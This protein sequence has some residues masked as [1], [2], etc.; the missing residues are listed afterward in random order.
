MHKQPLKHATW[1]SGA[2]TIVFA[3]GMTACQAVAAADSPYVLVTTESQRV[4]AALEFEIDAPNLKASEWILFVAKPPSL[5][6]QSIRSAKLDPS[7]QPYREIS[8]L[9]RR[10]LRA[11]IPVSNA[12]QEKRIAATSQV[13]ATLYARHLTPRRDGTA[14]SVV[15]PLSDAER[16]AAL[17]KSSMF[18]FAEEPFTDW[19]DEHRLHRRKRENDVDFGRRVFLAIVESYEYEYAAKMT[20]NAAHVCTVDKADCGGMA[21]LFTAAM[22]ANDIPSRV[23]SGCWAKSS[24]PAATL[25]GVPYY[26]THVK[27]EFF[28]SGVGWVPVD[29]SS[30]VLHDKSPEKTRYFGHDAGDFLTMHVDPELTVDTIHFGIKSFPWLQQFHFYATGKGKVDG[31]KY[32]MNWRVT[33]Q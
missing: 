21:V 30:A 1:R 12:A 29:L 6:G 26:Q 10:L 9:H 15:A 33:K 28:A 22:R 17:R 32:T 27:A 5:P 18:D 31:V 4:L 13:M 8:E 19:L 16:K 14:P 3:V 20:R 25:S 11:R 7:G 2:W 23:L 24:Q